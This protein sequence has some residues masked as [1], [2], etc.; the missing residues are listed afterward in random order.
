MASRMD[1]ISIREGRADRRFHADPHETSSGHV[2]AG[3]ASGVSTG[4]TGR[5]IVR[6]DVVQNLGIDHLI[7]FRQGA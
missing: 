1:S 6:D 4:L 2:T 3:L 7:S 5:P